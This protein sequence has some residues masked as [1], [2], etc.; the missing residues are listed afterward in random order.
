[1]VLYK[2]VLESLVWFNLVV[3]VVFSVHQPNKHKHFSLN[4]NEQRLET[5]SGGLVYLT[6]MLRA[7]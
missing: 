2:D 6:K 3:T 4:V 1:M 5:F 7:L